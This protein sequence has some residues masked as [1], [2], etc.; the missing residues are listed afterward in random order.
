MNSIWYYG[1]SGAILVRLLEIDARSWYGHILVI[2][3]SFGSRL[4]RTR[5]Y[6]LWISRA[7]L[8]PSVITLD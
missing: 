6:P 3:Y 1:R 7:D 2:V 5:W 8:G 4:C